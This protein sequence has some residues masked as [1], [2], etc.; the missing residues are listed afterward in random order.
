MAQLLFLDTFSHEDTE[1]N[2][3]LV[4]FPSSVIVEEVRVIPLG[5][6]VHIAGGNIAGGKSMRLGATLPNKFNLEFCIKTC[7][8][9]ILK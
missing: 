5:G 6:K 7:F 9:K 1:L 4:Q 8:H 2:L 3:D